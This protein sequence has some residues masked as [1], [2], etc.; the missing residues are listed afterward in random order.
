MVYRP[1]LVLMEHRLFL[2]CS[3]ALVLEQGPAM[4]AMRLTLT[5]APLRRITTYMATNFDPSIGTATRWRKGQASPNPG[6]RPKTKVL[7]EAL[8]AK[9]AE[10]SADDPEHRTNAEII[11]ENLVR[12]A[13]SENRGA[14]AAAAEI[15]NRV[16]G[17]AHSVEISDIRQELRDKSDFE[18]QYYL[19]HA[20]WRMNRLRL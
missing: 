5:S 11:A 8:R 4:G 10:V 3:H 19:E 17:R 18:L 13:S 20:C 7:S 6:G 2:A 12:I 9:L 1:F 16:E 14:I 15:G